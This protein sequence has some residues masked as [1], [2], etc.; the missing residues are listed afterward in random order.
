MVRE[1]DFDN[2]V[3]CQVYRFFVDEGRPPVAAETAEILATDQ[4]SVEASFGRLADAKIFVFAPGT[5]YIWMA[6]PLSAVPTPFT[7]TTPGRRLFANCIWDGLGT[8]AM[9]GGTGMVR[10]WCPDCGER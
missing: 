5:P 7:V 2:Q 3:R 6:N 1:A 10:T 8:I 4:A 9:L